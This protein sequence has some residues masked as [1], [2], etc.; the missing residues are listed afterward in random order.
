[1]STAP[2][3]HNEKRWAKQLKKL[4]IEETGAKLWTH[5]HCLRLIRKYAASREGRG[6]E[7]FISSI[8]EAERVK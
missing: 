6:V 4:A 3:S 1:M 2:Y 5:S 8:Y 7:E